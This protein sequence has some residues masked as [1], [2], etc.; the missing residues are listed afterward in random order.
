MYCR[1]EAINQLGFI[2]EKILSR[3]HKEFMTQINEVTQS[4]QDTATSN[5]R[6]ENISSG[7][8]R[9]EPVKAKETAVDLLQSFAIS[10]PSTTT[11]RPAKAVK[12]AKPVNQDN[13]TIVAKEDTAD[14]IREELL[15]RDVE[16]DDEE[17]STRQSK[18]LKSH[19][20]HNKVILSSSEESDDDTVM[21]P[22]V[23]T[24][25]DDICVVFTITL[26]D[27]LYPCHDEQPEVKWSTA[28]LPSATSA[29][30]MY[31]SDNKQYS[32]VIHP[33]APWQ[34]CRTL[35]RISNSKVTDVSGS[36]PVLKDK[37]KADNEDYTPK[38]SSRLRRKRTK[39]SEH[40]SSES[41]TEPLK[42]S[43]DNPA[44]NEQ[45]VINPTGTRTSKRVRR[46]P[47]KLRQ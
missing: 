42:I 36:S 8:T 31:A 21:S 9:E 5:Y 27:K 20:Q 12:Q 46:A 38:Q 26:H 18:E 16:R 43:A 6:D 47:I 32:C 35:C 37:D 39:D 25:T 24:H 23:T 41:E 1:P 22:S 13:C 14:V 28:K 17:N 4:L 34:R 45:V 44:A 40:P 29:A 33:A 15:S 7:G 19:K 10:T 11:K 30:V 3:K 2:A